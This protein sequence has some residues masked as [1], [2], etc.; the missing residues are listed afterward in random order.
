MNRIAKYCLNCTLVGQ[1]IHCGFDDYIIN[2]R[3]VKET[4]NVM[5]IG[6]RTLCNT[7]DNAQ[8]AGPADIKTQVCHCKRAV[9]K[10]ESDLYASIT[11]AS[12]LYAL[13]HLRPLERFGKYVAV[14]HGSIAAN[15]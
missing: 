12:A 2:W 5:C 7:L 10:G 13:D 1:Y 14:K 4:A 11:I 15:P 6:I 3:C 9:M 8:H